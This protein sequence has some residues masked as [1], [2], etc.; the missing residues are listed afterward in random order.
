MGYS[1]GQTELAE[2]R[3]RVQRA[4]QQYLASRQGG[5]LVVPE[6]TADEEPPVGKAEGD[7]A[8]ESAAIVGGICRIAADAGRKPDIEDGML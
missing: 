6:D 4:C 1:R 8:A 3:R 5:L 7:A 2:L